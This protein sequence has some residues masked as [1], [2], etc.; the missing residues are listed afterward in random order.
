MLSLIAN[1]FVLYYSLAMHIQDIFRVDTAVLEVFI[2]ARNVYAW[3]SFQFIL[4]KEEHF[5]DLCVSLR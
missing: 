4:S 5:A 3:L 2:F 1:W